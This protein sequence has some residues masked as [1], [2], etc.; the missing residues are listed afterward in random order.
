ML[1]ND[2]FE[3]IPKSTENFVITVSK[4]KNFSIKI[5]GNPTT[6]YGW[7]LENALTIDKNLLKPLNLNDVNGTDD[8]V[9]DVKPAGWVGGGGYYF[10]K[11]ASVN[12]GQ[13]ALTFSN[14]QIWDPSTIK[15]YE[16]NIV[17]N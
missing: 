8:Y 4:A 10:F 3:F 14:K 15:T 5:N 13:V 17:I 11:F 16:L 7:Y 6:G 2:T 12:E 1:E 9:A